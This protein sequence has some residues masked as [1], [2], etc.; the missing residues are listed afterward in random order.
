MLLLLPGPAAVAPVV[1]GAAA[2]VVAEEDEAAGAGAGAGVPVAAGVVDEDE[3]A[4]EADAAEASV[5]FTS[6]ASAAFASPSFFGA[7][8]AVNN[9]LSS[10]AHSKREARTLFHEEAD[11]VWFGFDHIEHQRCDGIVCRYGRHSA[12]TWTTGCV[13]SNAIA[14]ATARAHQ[15][16]TV[17]E[18]RSR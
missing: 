15:G 7:S 9:Q 16:R 11:M 8:I 10:G 4:E 1:A 6:V 14:I 17:S 5:G 13:V 12:E 2:G 18:C 3:E